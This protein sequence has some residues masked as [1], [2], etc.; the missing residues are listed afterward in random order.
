MAQQ[1]PGAFNNMLKSMQMFQQGVQSLVVS[2]ALNQANQQV[3]DIREQEGAEA[4][5]MNQ[6]RQVAQNLTMNLLQTGAPVE[7][8]EAAQ[9]ALVPPEPEISPLARSLLLQS[10][11]QAFQA[12]QAGKRQK[13][14]EQFFER[15][16][17]RQTKKEKTAQLRKIQGAFAK[18]ISGLR[19]GLS[20]VKTMGQLIDIDSFM[21]TSAAGILMARGSGEVGNLA[22]AEQ[23]IWKGRQDWA[24]QLHRWWKTGTMGKMTD[25][26]KSALKEVIRAYQKMGDREIEDIAQTYTS[27]LTYDPAFVEDDPNQLIKAVTGG[28]IKTFRPIGT[29]S[30]TEQAGSMQQPAGAPGLGTPQSTLNL[31][32]TWE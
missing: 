27:Q 19:K 31:D 17:A 20:K 18:E 1:L 3:Q 2:R 8:I 6:I 24:R 25:A 28:K 22:K 7:R 21:A 32:V 9:K 16:E 10:R 12:E 11:S 30:P 23:E 29:E 14:Q 4:E 26:D 13:L 15:R 5:K